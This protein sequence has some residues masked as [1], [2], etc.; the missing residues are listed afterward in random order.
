MPCRWKPGTAI[1][2]PL[3]LSAQTIIRA[4]LAA[5][6]VFGAVLAVALNAVPSVLYPA[7]LTINMR[8]MSVGGLLRLIAAH[9]TTVVGAGLF[10][11]FGILALRGILRLVFRESG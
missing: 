10:G 5:V 4:K 11:F 6:V 7:F 9:A 8:G 3:P 2:G 1:L